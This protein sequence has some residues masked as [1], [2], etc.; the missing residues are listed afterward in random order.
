MFVVL[1]MITPEKNFIKRYK[2]RKSIE[3]SSLT[4]CKTND[5][6]PFFT[7]DV[8]D[9][10]Q[11]TNWESVAKKCGAY[12]S[13]IVAPRSCH[14]PDNCGLKRFVP[15]VMSSVLVFNTALDAIEKSRISS[16]NL[17]ITLTDRNAVHFSRVCRL[18][19]FAP[20]VRIIT[21]HPERYAEP[22]IKAYE[23]FGA[24]LIIR[25]R[26]EPVSKPE[27]IICG[28][29][30]VTPSMKNA[31]VFSSKKKSSDGLVIYGNSTALTKNHLDA[32]GSGINSVDFAGAV[33]ELCGSSEYRNSVFESTAS[34]CFECDSESAAKCLMCRFNIN[35]T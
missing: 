1:R 2:Q 4:Q 24:S 15:S 31:I 25:S 7:L 5:G 21:S 22:C 13:R 12:S 29:G 19:P 35:N 11:N 33:T 20:S 14:I 28:D 10:K 18:L 30:A 3:K 9:K 23:D 27:I 34:N 26:Y 16:N 8:T 6:L 32:I 17:C